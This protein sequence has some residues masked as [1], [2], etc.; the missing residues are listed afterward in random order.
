M[1]SILGDGPVEQLE[2]VD[3]STLRRSSMNRL[4][5]TSGLEQVVS[6][7]KNSPSAL[8]LRSEV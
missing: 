7:A 4:M 1:E 2:R 8:F 5:M 3:E 6:I